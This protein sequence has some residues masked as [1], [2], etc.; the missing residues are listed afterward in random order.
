MNDELEPSPCRCNWPNKAVEDPW[1]PVAYDHEMGEYQLILDCGQRGKGI[2]VLHYCP[3]CGGALP[4]S[5]RATFFTDPTDSD[6]AKV[7]ELMQPVKTVAQMF[8]VLG[9]PST[10]IEGEA[11]NQYDFDNLFESLKLVVFEHK[12]CIT[13]SFVGK[14]KGK[15]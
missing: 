10:R 5:K 11:R 12:Q 15:A 1:F 3:W 13:Y 14:W 6:V 9:E 7:R 8:E 4:K 2:A